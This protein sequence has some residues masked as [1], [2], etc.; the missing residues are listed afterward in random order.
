[1]LKEYR[2]Q[3][4]ATQW[5]ETTVKAHTLED[6]LEVADKEFADGDFIDAD[7]GFEID[8]EDFWI[9]THDGLVFTNTHAPEELT[10]H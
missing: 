1:M 9:Q 10:K 7:G 3:R 6:A 2:V 8:E 4:R 5:I